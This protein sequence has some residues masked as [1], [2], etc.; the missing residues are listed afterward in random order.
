MQLLTSL[1]G[2]PAGLQHLDL[3]N[4]SV[5]CHPNP[6]WN[7]AHLTS[8]AATL[9]TLQL[10]DVK[11]NPAAAEALSQALLQLHVLS[12]LHLSDANLD[13]ECLAA[14]APALTSLAPTLRDLDLDDNKNILSVEGLRKALAPVTGLT[15]LLYFQESLDRWWEVLP[16]LQGM[17]SLAN[18]YLDLADWGEDRSTAEIATFLRSGSSPAIEALTMYGSGDVTCQGLPQLLHAMAGKTCLSQLTF[19]SMIDYHS[20]D[21]RMAVVDLASALSKLIRL[22]HLDLGYNFI[23]PHDPAEFL[24]N[25]P[26]AALQVLDG[27]EAGVTA[28]AASLKCLTCLQKLHLRECHLGLAGARA[29]APALTALTMLEDLDLSDNFLQDQGAQVLAPALCAL[30][31]LRKL[32]IS[33]N[34][35]KLLD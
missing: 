16:A 34:R 12:T 25:L 8:C 27:A 24:L 35:I 4:T 33:G 32:D 13:D 30:P 5:T 29:L 19:R 6:R 21:T 23:G 7:F 20:D 11:F 15:R 26:A 10:N 18:V 14:L 2:L 3:T 31:R 9:T 17:R 28:F 22:R 1:F